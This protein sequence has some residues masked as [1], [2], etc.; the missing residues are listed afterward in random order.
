MSMSMAA[1]LEAWQRGDACCQ[2]FRPGSELSY[3]PLPRP[4][5]TLRIHPSF[6]H[7]KLIRQ[8][9]TWRFRH[10]ARYDGCFI[11]ME[12]DGSL[13]VLCHPTPDDEA[14]LL[15]DKLSSLLDLQ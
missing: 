4:T 12:A 15:I 5:L 2:A 3:S 10:P 14:Y 8:V 9:L 1:F 7:D 11:S 13:A 6:L